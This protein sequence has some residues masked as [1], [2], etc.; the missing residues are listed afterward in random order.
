M[1]FICSKQENI[2][3]QIEQVRAAVADAL[4]ARGIGLRHF[5]QEIREGRR[6]DGPFMVGALAWA[7]R[8]Q[9]CATN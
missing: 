1:F 5:H 4:E 6:D 2:M 8:E 3:K 9:P 7:E